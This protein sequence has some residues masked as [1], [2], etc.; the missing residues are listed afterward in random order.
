MSLMP[1]RVT[2]YDVA[3]DIVN[4]EMLGEPR[5]LVLV[6]YL[7]LVYFLRHGEVVEHMLGQLQLR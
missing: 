6:G 3:Y 7:S 5:T 2:R 1:I 4:N